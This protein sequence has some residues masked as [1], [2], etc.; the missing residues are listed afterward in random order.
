MRSRSKTAASASSGPSSPPTSAPRWARA[1]TSSSRRDRPASLARA[2][3]RGRL[4]SR[5][6]WSRSR[7]SWARSC[8]IRAAL[9]SAPGTS[10]SRVRSWPARASE[11]RQASGS[12]TARPAPRCAVE[13]APDE[14]RELLGLARPD[15]AA[16]AGG[17]DQLV[18]VLHRLPERQRQH[19]VARRS[20]RRGRPR[21]PPRR[22]RRARRGARA[23]SRRGPAG[24]SGPR[25]GLT[26]AV[27][28]APARW[29]L[30]VMGADRRAGVGC[31]GGGPSEGCSHRS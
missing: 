30:P 22:A 19:H 18:A 26:A 10:A 20:R 9:A 14:R 28:V 29:A 4:G 13:P 11:S 23:P 2:A 21:A 17:D 8:L 24:T 7:S 12:E 3:S 27:R 6:T 5:A 31:G 1:V 15:P 25:R 16:V